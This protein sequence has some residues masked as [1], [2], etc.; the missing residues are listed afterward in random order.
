MMPS[1]AVRERQTSA[2]CLKDPPS[3]PSLEDVAAPPSETL[4]EVIYPSGRGPIGLRGDHAPLSWE[5]TEK[6]ARVVGDAH[7]FRIPLAADELLEFKVVRGE[8]WAA[9]RNYVVH[10]GDHL[11]VE[12]YFD[13]TQPSFE[14]GLE[15]DGTKIDVVLPPSYEEQPGKRY[16]VLYLLDGQSMWQHSS[17]PFGTWGLDGTMEFLYE[18]GAIEELVVVGVHTAENRLDKLSPVPD[19][20]YGGGG[21]ARFLDFVAGPVRDAVNAK[22][23][24]LTDRANTGIL[25][26][27]LGGL[28]S[29]YAAWMKPEIFGK[30]GCLSSSFW[31][32]NRWAVRLAQTAPPPTPR[33]YIYLDSGVSPSAMEEDVRLIDGFHHTRSMHRALTKAGFDIGAEVHRLVFPGHAH[34][35]ASW[36]S[37]VALPLQ[38]LFP[39]VPHPVDEAAWA[40]VGEKM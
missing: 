29:F 7:L 33:P 32:A 30:A 34:Q 40:N 37:R 2:V 18:L 4:V 23:R 27:S 15:I 6:P 13:R 1:E 38:L 28:F 36:A 8:D 14:Q 26:S 31:W 5:H 20:N 39:K 16:P 12:P 9:G 17:D 10:A 24:T 22:Y 25:G 11:R 19:P 35:A 21:G 3:S